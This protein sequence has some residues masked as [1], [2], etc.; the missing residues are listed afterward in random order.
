MI[1]PTYFLK[2]LDLEV[3]R[4][5]SLGDGRKEWEVS[6]NM[7]KSKDQTG[8]CTTFEVESPPF[9]TWTH[10]CGVFYSEMSQNG[11]NTHLRKSRIYLNGRGGAI[12]TQRS[13][14]LYCC[15]ICPVFC[16]VLFFTYVT[17]AYSKFKCF[18]VHV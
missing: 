14:C 7:C 13:P 10:F 16:F 15:T 17:Y 2:C 1:K 18:I 6:F 4:P 3:K 12:S 11:N 9:Q 5:I 8:D